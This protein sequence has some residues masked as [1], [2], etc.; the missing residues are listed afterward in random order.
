MAGK[1]G[2]KSQLPTEIPERY[3]SSFLD[4]LDGRSR[5]ARELRSRWSALANAQGGERELSYM[6]R[7]LVNRFIHLE[8]WLEN[9]EAALANGQKIDEAKYFAAL[10]SFAGL[11][12]KLGLERRT[13]P[14]GNTLAELLKGMDMATGEAL[15]RICP[16]RRIR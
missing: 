13:K 14:I 16:S 12:G 7:S 4:E 11:L 3:T 2:Q 15:T 10:N 5:V 1:A 9:Q 6:R 8:C